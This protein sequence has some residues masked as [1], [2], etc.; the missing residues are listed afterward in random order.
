VLLLE[1]PHPATTSATPTR[2]RID[3]LSTVSLL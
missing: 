2:A 3:G 1:L